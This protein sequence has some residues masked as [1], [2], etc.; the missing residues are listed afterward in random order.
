LKLAKSRLGQNET[1][2][3]RNILRN[4]LAQIGTISDKN[5]NSARIDISKTLDIIDQV[6]DKKPEKYASAVDFDPG[7]ILITS[8]GSSIYAVGGDGKLYSVTSEKIQELGKFNFTPKFLEAD[9]LYILAYDGQG[10]I[11]VYDIKKNSIVDHTLK[12]AVESRDAKFYQ[13][14]LYT[15]AST[16]IYKYM[17][18]IISNSKKTT[19]GSDGTDGDLISIAID[20]NVY[21]LSSDGKIIKFFKG[22]KE[23][24]FTIYLYDRYYK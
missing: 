13:N 15:L 17:D 2:E 10:I 3:A 7:F 1:R 4:A 21:A 14:N 11:A 23:S 12:D 8:V 20:G 24:E 5:I 16:D 19:W 18:A 22:K 9:A 6:S